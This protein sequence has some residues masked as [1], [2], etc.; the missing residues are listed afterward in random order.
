MAVSEKDLSTI[1]KGVTKKIVTHIIEKHP[2]LKRQESYLKEYLLDKK[3]IEDAAKKEIEYLTKQKN[4]YSPD[5][6]IK[7]LTDCI[8][9]Y[10][11]PSAGTKEEGAIRSYLTE[12]GKESILREYENVKVPWWLTPAR[13]IVRKFVGKHA[14]KIDRIIEEG[15][16]EFIELKDLAQR[17][18]GSLTPRIERLLKDMV[19]I[20]FAYE[21]IDIL[22]HYG[23]LKANQAYKWREAIRKSIKRGKEEMK[24]G[25]LEIISKYGTAFF[26][27]LGIF[28]LAFSAANISGF[29]ILESQTKI[30]AGY[31][32]AIGFVLLIIGL[33]LSFRRGRT[34]NRKL[35]QKKQA[36]R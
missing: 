22:Q 6:V 32:I 4:I 17:Y 5:D 19:P 31:P 34:K 21:S 36:K 29:V 27:I 28:L 25:L 23:D 3:A 26:L 35:R 10:P 9:E 14:K 20:G 30:P 2:R 12:R 8:E 1:V 18:R 15:I 33:F 24:E 16:A 11:G 13:R 7:H